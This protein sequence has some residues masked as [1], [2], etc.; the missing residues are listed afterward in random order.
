[1]LQQYVMLY[2]SISFLLLTYFL[3]VT[4]LVSSLLHLLT[5]FLLA[6]R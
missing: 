4:H 2:N 3:S 6:N 1:M 5:A